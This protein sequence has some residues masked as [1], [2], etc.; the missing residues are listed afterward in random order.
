MPLS[1]LGN[2]ESLSG[3]MPNQAFQGTRLM[4]KRKVRKKSKKKEIYPY[5]APQSKTSIAERT[6]GEEGGA[7]NGRL[8]CKYGKKR[9]I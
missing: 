9:R 8:G 7:C 5:V 4:R 3:G 6:E 2:V 1:P